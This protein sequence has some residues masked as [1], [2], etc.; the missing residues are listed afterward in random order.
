[1]FTGQGLSNEQTDM[2]EYLKRLLSWRK[3]K[4]VIHS[5]QLKHFIPK[6]GIYV[7]FRYDRNNTVMVAINNSG[8][9]KKID[10]T[11]YDEFLKDVSR[12]TDILTGKTFD[13]LSEIILPSKTALILEL[14]K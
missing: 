13:N 9:E 7:Y 1:M 2:H 10:K 5:G 12:G 14:A 3:D 8:E 6:D 4:E 11:R